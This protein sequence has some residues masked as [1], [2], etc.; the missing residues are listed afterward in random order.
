MRKY[1]RE[2]EEDEIISSTYV[3]FIGSWLTG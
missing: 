2:A 1:G 3:C